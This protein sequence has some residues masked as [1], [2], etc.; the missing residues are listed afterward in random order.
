MKVIT[1]FEALDID[2]SYLEDIQDE[3]ADMDEIREMLFEA[4]ELDFDEKVNDYDISLYQNYEEGHFIFGVIDADRLKSI[5]NG[6]NME[7]RNQF[8]DALGALVQGDM[9]P[10]GL[11]MD[12]MET[13]NLWTAARELDN[14]WWY[15]TEHTAY[16]LNDGGFSY[17]RVTLSEK[18]LEDILNNPEKYVVMNVSVK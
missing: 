17:F 1:S 5:A 13:Y 8:L 15:N 9:T 2:E 16:L 10:E 7:I 4:F 6:W 18:I 11:P 3:T 12:T 14:S